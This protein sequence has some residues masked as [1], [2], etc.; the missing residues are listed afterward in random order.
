MEQIKSESQSTRES[1]NDRHQRIYKLIRER[2]SLLH[3]PPNTVLSEIEL[4]REFDVSRTPIRHVLQRLRFEGL[5]DIRNGVGT[6][7]TNIDLKTMK[8]VYDLRMY[9]SELIADLSPNE[10][11]SEHLNAMESLLNRSKLLFNQRSPEAYGQ[12]CNDLHEV[13]NSLI[14]SIPLREITDNLYYRSA[15]IWITFLPNLDWESVIS[16]QV[17]ETSEMLAA[18]KRNDLRGVVQVRRYYLNCILS[19]ISDYLKGD[20]KVRPSSIH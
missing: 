9:L 3:Y 10:I 8:E 5:V 4:A 11:T 7:V 2:I 18:M 6:V 20:S 15:R 17:L 19:R 12:L 13:L 14:G 16:D 1:S